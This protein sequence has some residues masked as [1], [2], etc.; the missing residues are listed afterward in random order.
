MAR[1]VWATLLATTAVLWI[2]AEVPAQVRD[3]EAQP[4]DGFNRWALLVGVDDYA[5]AEKLRYCGA[6]VRALADRI[7]AGGF[8]RYHIRLL[9]D[10]A[11]QTQYRPVKAHI[12]AKLKL[13]LGLAGLLARGC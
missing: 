1:A 2:A 4:L 6:D 7:V 3:I 10:E 12:E 13:V 5:N 8:R 11:Q 9:H